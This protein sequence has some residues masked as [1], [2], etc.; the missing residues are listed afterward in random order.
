MRRRNAEN[1]GE[2]IRQYLHLSHL[3]TPL[4]EYRLVQLWPQVAGKAIAA[5]TKQVY[6]YNQ[7][8]HVHLDSPALRSE[9]LMKRSKLIKEL[10]DGVGSIIIYGIAVH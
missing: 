2:V 5:H 9:I 7:Q 1:I 3:E 6:I 8:L 10:N 4:N